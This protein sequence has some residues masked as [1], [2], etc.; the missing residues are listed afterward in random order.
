VSTVGRLVA[1]AEFP[2]GR[3]AVSI[4]LGA[5]A[6]AFGVAL[7]ATAGY[8][9]ARAAEQPPI[10]ALTTTIVVVRFLALARPLA[11]YRE[12][13][14]S[15]DVTLR[16][17]G[18]IRQSVYARIEP[19]APA[20]LDAYRRGDLVSRLV[21]DVD[22]LQ[23]LYL[24]G[25]APPLVALVVSIAC[26]VAVAFASPAAAVVLAVGLLL[27]GVA[28]P[29]VAARLARYVGERQA[30]ARGDLS[31]ELVEI[32][33]GAPELVAFGRER[34]A[35]ARI[36][37]LDARLMRLSR[38]DALVAGV[39]DAASVLVAGLTTVAVL[40]VA[41]S[42]H[43]AGTLDRVLI[44]ALTL[45]ALSSF[46]AIAPLPGAARELRG[47]LAA[48]ERVLDL[49]ER[50]PV[51]RDPGTPA[52]LGVRAGVVSLEGVSA[53]YGPDGRTVL[54]GLDLT[55]PPGR[56]V[57][58]VGPSGAGK[59]TVTNLLLRF[60]DPVDG[61][62]TIDGRDIRELRQE[63]VRRTFAL[64]GQDAH[65]FDS[66]IRENLRLAAPDATDGQLWNALARARLSEWVE[67]LPDGLDTLVGE[68][69][70]RLSG[71]QRQRLV[72]ARALLADAPVLILDEPTAQLDP[73]TAEA[74]VTDAL[75]AAAD[76][77]VLLITH[78][79][80]GLALVDEI[81]AL[82]GA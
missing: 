5:L 75:D 23:G 32:L 35:L 29:L 76:R 81:V 2:R 45:L 17:L 56:R 60:L 6:V 31:S 7:M 13:L 34:D 47:T 8:L 51:V 3:V 80:E 43:D 18:R 26:V 16:A 65:V 10:L 25:L 41:V 12:R 28:L 55:L 72:V 69:G 62:V 27:G 9:I 48:G 40:A 30:A 24:R 11:R 39:G 33:R 67:S 57:A 63:D 36:G 68:E 22:S 78:R 44:A 73:A 59:T 82:P 64:A 74:L 15:H 14:T 70:A 21:A 66:T 20:E 77:S 61:R 52:A 79:P 19:L 37:E 53:R 1:L 54:D 58:L 46:D 4:V 50:N 38:R 42:A 71:G 49:V